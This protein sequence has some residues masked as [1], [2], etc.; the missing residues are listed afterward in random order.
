MSTCRICNASKK[1]ETAKYCSQCGNPYSI[2]EQLK[3]ISELRSKGIYR[4]TFPP[5]EGEFDS[6]YKALSAVSHSAWNEDREF[7]G[8]AKVQLIESTVT[9]E[10]HPYEC[11]NCKNTSNATVAKSK[12]GL[13]EY[14]DKSNWVHRK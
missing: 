7:D 10:T 11:G 2:A 3:Y 8:Q 14:C 4:V 12:H 5:Q 1:D 9:I 6:M 13:C